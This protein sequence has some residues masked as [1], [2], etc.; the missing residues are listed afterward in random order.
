MSGASKSEGFGFFL[1]AS[2][3]QKGLGLLGSEGLGCK[4]L[5]F[6][7]FAGCNMAWRISCL[8]VHVKSMRRATGRLFR[9]TS[10]TTGFLRL[11]GICVSGG[12]ADSP[13]PEA[14]DLQ[15]IAVPAQKV[16]LQD[17]ALDV[18]WLVGLVGSSLRMLWF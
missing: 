5:G 7:V 4:S 8:V 10:F 17:F 18:K 16:D 1:R 14:K 11:D 2:L 9:E 3:Q 15:C 6:R 13:S 12:M